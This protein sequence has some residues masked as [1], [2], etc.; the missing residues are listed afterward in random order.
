MLHVSEEKESKHLARENK[1]E[2]RI[3]PILDDEEVITNHQTPEPQREG[4]KRTR[5]SPNKTYKCPYQ[6]GQMDKSSSENFGSGQEQQGDQVSLQSS[7]ISKATTSDLSLPFL[8]EPCHIVSL[9]KEFV[10]FKNKSST[11][12]LVKV[13]GSKTPE[14]PGNQ[15]TW[16]NNGLSPISTPQSGTLMPSAESPE[17]SENL[18]TQKSESMAVNL[19]LLSNNSIEVQD[20]TR[21]PRSDST[22]SRLQNDKITSPKTLSPIRASFTSPSIPSTTNNINSD[23]HETKHHTSG[24]TEMD[25]VNNIDEDELLNLENPSQI[26]RS[27]LPTSEAVNLED[28]FQ[29]LSVLQRSTCLRCFSSGD[30]SSYQVCQDCRGRDRK[31]VGKSSSRRRLTATSSSNSEKSPGVH[32]RKM[33]RPHSVAVTEYWIC[34]QCTLQ[35]D[36]NSNRCQVCHWDKNKEVK[37]RSSSG[38]CIHLTL[39]CISR[40]NLT[41]IIF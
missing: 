12:R 20:H 30:S 27:S 1:S 35:N 22:N 37:V 3:E 26:R 24:P 32:S 28:D 33:D 9:E 11:K 34:Q 16:T 25:A 2:W 29:D 15:K 13:D 14:A 19:S 6:P 21:E 31:V 4:K 38:V 39:L 10:R 8:D 17:K 7:N 5:E 41:I 36:V 40:S 18:V 23:S